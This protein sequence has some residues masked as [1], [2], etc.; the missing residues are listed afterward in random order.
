MDQEPSIG[1]IVHVMTHPHD[2]AGFQSEI[3]PA[4]ITEVYSDTV[5]LQVF[6]KH[7]LQEWDNVPFSEK[8]KAGYWSWPPRV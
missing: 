3:R 7:G 1:R 5:A 6:Y 4:I 8:Y 2:A